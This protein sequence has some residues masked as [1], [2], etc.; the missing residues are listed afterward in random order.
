[1]ILAAA[2]QKGGV[3]K[4]T[5]V[6]NL[7]AALAQRGRRV[8]IIDC[9]PQANATSGLGIARRDIV[10]STY[11]VLVLG[12]PLAE[13]RLATQVGG[14][15]LIPSDIALAGAEIELVSVAR[16][17][18]RLTYALEALTDD[19][20]DYVLLD[21]PPSL[22]L[23]T[24]NAVVAAHSLLVPIQC[25]FYAMEGLGLL[26]HTINLLRRDLNP[27]LRIA[28]IV[29]TLHDARLTLANQVVDEVRARFGEDVLDPLIPRNVR[30]SEAP[31]YGLPITLYAPTS[32][33]AQAY[34]ELAANLE[35][36]LEDAGATRAP[37]LA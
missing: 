11:D 32:R 22:G 23:L 36:R 35:A 31:S 29:L 30:L 7:G 27:R 1:M 19:P 10:A 28:G 9:D 15:E 25:E 3:G 4:T 16:R 2:N 6:V 33:G 20:L 13:A 37:S 34:R 26:T 8:L 14:L 17:E 5:T 21:C 24:V 18:K 12:R